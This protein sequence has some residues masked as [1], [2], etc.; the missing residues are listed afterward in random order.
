MAQVFPQR[1]PKTPISRWRQLRRPPTRHFDG[2]VIVGGAI[3]EFVGEGSHKVFWSLSA[4]E[5]NRGF[6]LRAISQLDK[7]CQLDLSE[8]VKF[9]RAEVR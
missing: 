9:L 1:C 3:R 2:D 6:C 4:L 7:A 5:E 8:T